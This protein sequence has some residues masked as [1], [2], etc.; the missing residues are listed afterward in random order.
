[1]SRSRP[2]SATSTKPGRKRSEEHTP[3][4]QSRLHLVCRLLL[5]KKNGQQGRSHQVVHQVGHP[6]L[7]QGGVQP[8]HHVRRGRRRG[9]EQR[10]GHQVVPQGRQPGRHGGP[11]QPGPDVRQGRRHHHQQGRGHQVVRQS[12]GR[13]LL[14]CHVQPPPNFTLF[15]YTT[16]YR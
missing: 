15:P 3:E 9:G 8:R 12:S 16:L 2:R 4:L 7:H 10:R 5:E 11:V 1:M 13:Q 6:G 14:F